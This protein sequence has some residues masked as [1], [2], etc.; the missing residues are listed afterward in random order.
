MRREML[1]YSPHEYMVPPFLLSQDT[2][3][4]GYQVDVIRLALKEDKPY[5]V[6]RLEELPTA[7]KAFFCVLDDELIS[8][9]AERRRICST[10]SYLLLNMRF[11]QKMLRLA[12]GSGVC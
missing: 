2:R 9:Q 5:H 4:T 7:Y 8:I 11:P 10:S 3:C 6:F 1:M 12:N